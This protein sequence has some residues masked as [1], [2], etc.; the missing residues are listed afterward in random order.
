MEKVIIQEVLELKEKSPQQKAEA[1]M[2]KLK[3]T[4]PQPSSMIVIRYKEA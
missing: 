2:P 3:T 1:I 4:A